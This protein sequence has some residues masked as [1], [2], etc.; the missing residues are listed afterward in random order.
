MK[1]TMESQ[2]HGE[3]EKVRNALRELDSTNNQQSISPCLC[4]SVV[5]H[6]F[7]PG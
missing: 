1:F 4:V 7:F 6:S 3:N 5:N 2:S